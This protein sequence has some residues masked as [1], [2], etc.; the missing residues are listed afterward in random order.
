VTYYSGSSYHGRIA[1]VKVDK[2]S[3]SLDPTLGDDV[4][5]AAER[6]GVSVSAWLAQAAAAQLRKQALADFLASWQAK[7]GRITDAEL[8]KA[9]VEIGLGHRRRP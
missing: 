5:A 6:S 7:H 1:S 4:R 3:I 2:L 8:A 9:R